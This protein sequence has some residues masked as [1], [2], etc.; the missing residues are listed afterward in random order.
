MNRTATTRAHG[1]WLACLALYLVVCAVRWQYVDRYGGTVPFWD[2]WDAGAAHLFK[3]W[4]EGT[5]SLSDLWS[6]HNEHRIL[7]TRLLGLA[8][9]GTVG[10]WDNHLEAQVNVFLFALVPALMFRFALATRQSW[11][12]IAMA[13]MVLSVSVLPFSW[14]NFLVGFQSQFYFLLLAALGAMALAATRPWGLAANIAMFVLAVLACLTSA[15]GLLALLAC[16]GLYLLRLWLLPREHPVRALALAVAL[17][18]GAAI[19]YATTPVVP[20][21]QG[22]RAQDAA[23]L[24]DAINHVL[25]WPLKVRHWAPFVLWAPGVAG[26][27]LILVRRRAATSD[28]FML[29]CLAWS[30]L[31]ALAI[32]Y[33]RGNGL[34]EVPSRYTDALIPGLVANA[35]FALRLLAEAMEKPAK[36][37]AAALALCA[38][39][40]TVYACAQAIRLPGDLAAMRDRHAHSVIQARNVACYL[41]SGAP[42]CLQA[43]HFQIPYPDPVRL[44]HLLDDPTIRK[45]LVRCD[46]VPCQGQEAG[47]TTAP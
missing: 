47:A 20:G 38:A 25:G 34:M 21:H 1:T 6:A 31:Q 14:E 19:A 33:S 23:W 39:F 17:V 5:L 30:L 2:E 29:A 7:P 40:F 13:V 10:H 8:V 9:F 18:A 4:V 44:Q 15:S 41:D 42:A 37:R 27:V 3:P 46:I 26:I 28:L 16:A 43:G 11:L 45:L 36:V 12:R 22:L 24:L 32:G 35:W